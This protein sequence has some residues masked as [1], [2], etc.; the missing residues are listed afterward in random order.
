MLLLLLLLALMRSCDIIDAPCNWSTHALRCSRA[1][2]CRSH[3]LGYCDCERYP[4][5]SSS[6]TWCKAPHFAATHSVVMSPVSWE[7]NGYSASTGRTSFYLVSVC[8]LALPIGQ[9]CKL[10]LSLSFRW[11]LLAHWQLTR[12]MCDANATILNRLSNQSPFRHKMRLLSSLGMV[13]NSFKI[14]RKF[15]YSQSCEHKTILILIDSSSCIFCLIHDKNDEN[16][17]NLMKIEKVAN[18]QLRMMPKW[19]KTPS[20][21]TSLM[22]TFFFQKKTMDTH[23]FPSYPVSILDL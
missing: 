1:V 6:S 17:D 16:V 3:T 12:S 8:R 19:P 5:S 15:C 7:E 20:Y 4:S 13:N 18:S 2:Y 22:Q 10:K 23:T 14:M 11:S 9:E 21:S